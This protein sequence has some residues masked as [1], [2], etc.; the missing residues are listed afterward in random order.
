MNIWEIKNYKDIENILDIGKIVIIGLTVKEN[1]NKEK[2]IIRKFLKE[3]SKEYKNINFVY[4]NVGEFDFGK[5]N[6]LDDNIDSYPMVYH[7]QLSD[8][9][10]HVKCADKQSLDESFKAVEEY[11][12]NEK[13]AE[14]DENVNLLIN[15]MIEKNKDLSLNFSKELEKRSKEKVI[16]G[17]NTL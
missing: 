13:I 8:I 11:Y 5:L 4:M 12:I 7:L 14:C 16:S 1:K 10:V 17:E 9:L 2:I 6:I 15:K 3:K